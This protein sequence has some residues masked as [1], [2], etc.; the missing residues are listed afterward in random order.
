MNIILMGGSG[1]SGST[2]LRYLLN[3]HENI[4]SGQE[5]NFFNKETLFQKWN[6]DKLKIIPYF[7]Y[8]TTLG[9][10]IHRRNSLHVQDYGWEKKEIKS[11]LKRNATINS[12]ANEFFSRVIKK[13]GKDIIIE[14]TPTNCYSFFDFLQA[15]P[16][17]KVI[18]IARNPYDAAAS[19]YKR[20]RS[21]FE[22]AS[23]WIYGNASALRVKDDA[24]YVLVKYEDLINDQKKTF[25]SIF[26][27]I[28]VDPK[29]TDEKNIVGTEAK[30]H[31][32]WNLNPQAGIVKNRESSFEKLADDEKE[33]LLTALS[34]IQVSDKH[35]R[36][37]SIHFTSCKHICQVLGYT[38]TPFVNK[39]YERKLRSI[40]FWDKVSRTIKNY[41]TSVTF[42]PVQINDE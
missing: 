42:Y 23:I 21:F 33:K 6:K 31:A 4:Y 15:F 26:S 35:A 7:P 12:L 10:Q 2:L 13:T 24:R 3:Q 1:S 37:K 18:H 20:G 17:G 27:F 36:K 38:Y 39:E 8:Y 16:T 41:H 14:K 25:E 5:L 34:V 9:F 29:R 30:A 22:A 11:L 32:S 19:L 28:G 40:V